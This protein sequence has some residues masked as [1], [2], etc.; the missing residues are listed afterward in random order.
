[1]LKCFYNNKR[2]SIRKDFFDNP[3]RI[4]DEGNRAFR[5]IFTH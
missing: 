3:P 4:C 5:L 2:Y 1:L